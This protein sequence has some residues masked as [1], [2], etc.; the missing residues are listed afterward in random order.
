[1]DRE[2][3]LSSASPVSVLHAFILPPSLWMV[4]PHISPKGQRRSLRV[5]EALR[6]HRGGDGIQAQDCLT[7][8]PVCFLCVFSVYHVKAVMSWGYVLVTSQRAG[9]VPTATSQQR[10]SKIMQRAGQGRFQVRVRLLLS[11][12]ESYFLPRKGIDLFLGWRSRHQDVMAGTAYSHLRS[13][14]RMVPTLCRRQ[15][16]KRTTG[17]EP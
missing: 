3:R 2:L 1:M 15:S 9:C 6:S 7:S 13:N 11:V 8:Q 16:L 5:S 17:R 12:Y 4:H 14:E 10:G